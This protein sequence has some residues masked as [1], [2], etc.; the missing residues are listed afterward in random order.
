MALEDLAMMRAVHG[1]TVVYPAD[2][3]AAATLTAVMADLPGISYI[4]TT[5][6]GTPKLYDAGERFPIGGS[7]VL[8][9]S[10]GDRATI[11][12][13]GVT[14]Y[15]ALKAADELAG[16]DTAVRVID[17]YSVKPIDAAALVRALRATG[18][19]VVAEDHWID[20]G[21]G[22]AVLQALA[23]EGELSGRVL[24]LAVTEACGNAVRHAYAGDDG[25]VTVVFL[26]TGD[27]LDMIVEDHGV[28]LDTLEPEREPEPPAPFSDPLESGMGMP[29]I[30][31]IVDEL[32]VG[33][34]RDGHGTVLRMTKY[35]PTIESVE[36]S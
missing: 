32:E 11:V 9:S 30:R 24:K 23:G 16:E 26:V 18:L 5:R 31:A 29:I 27:R 1:S 33:R 3:N 36:L 4:R 17:A 10:D 35:L 21:L 8:R 15:E 34:G 12:G 25:T 13:A 2:G 22:D 19:V 6:E 7:K 14:V 28:G 20:G